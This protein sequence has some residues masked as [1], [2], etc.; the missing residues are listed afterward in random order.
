MIKSDQCSG[1]RDHDKGGAHGGMSQNDPN[2]GGRQ[3]DIAVEKNIPAAAMIRGTIMGEIRMPITNVRAGISGRLKP[4]TA[5][6][7][8]AVA[9]KVE[10]IAMMKLLRTAPCQ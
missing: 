6:V 5:I 10:K 2:V 9:M 3:T 4:R 1:N 8:S 7:P